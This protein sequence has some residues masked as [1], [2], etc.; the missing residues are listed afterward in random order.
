MNL[1]PTTA[2]PIGKPQPADAAAEKETALRS[3]FQK[4]VAG[5]FYKQMFKAMRKT[6]GK[7]AFFH[8]GRA[9]EI[10]RAQMDQELSEQLAEQPG[11]MFSETLFQSFARNLKM[12]L[13]KPAT[14]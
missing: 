12:Q 7:P 10:F 14:K 13:A 1:S 6:Q 9:E 11:N 4:F 2:V 8:G 5:T 3:A